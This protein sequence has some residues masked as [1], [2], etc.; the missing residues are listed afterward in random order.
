MAMAKTWINGVEAL[1]SA[2]CGGDF[3]RFVVDGVEIGCHADRSGPRV[4]WS[5]VAGRYDYWGRWHVLADASGP[6]PI[7][8]AEAAHA[9]YSKPE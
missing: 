5:A 7:A 9:A 8:A 2:D 1:R 4:S 6:S 3:L